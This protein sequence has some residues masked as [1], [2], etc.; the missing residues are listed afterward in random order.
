VEPTNVV[1]APSINVPMAAIRTW[2]VN[3]MRIMRVVGPSPNAMSHRSHRHV[4]SAA[5]TNLRQLNDAVTK[6]KMPLELGA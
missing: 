6:P 3:A 4:R 1:S 5:T 2:S